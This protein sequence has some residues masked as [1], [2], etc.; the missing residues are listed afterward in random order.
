MRL[1]AEL[2]AR[3]HTRA[4]LSPHARM[5]SCSLAHACLVLVGC[6]S[7]ALV[8]CRLTTAPSPRTTVP[9]THA[10]LPPT[11]AQLLRRVLT[12]SLYDEL[13]GLRTARG[14][15]LDACIRGGVDWSASHDTGSVVRSAKRRAAI[16]PPVVSTPSIRHAR[17]R[18][19]GPA[20]RHPSRSTPCCQPSPLLPLRTNLSSLLSPRTRLGACHERRACSRATRTRTWSSRR[21]SNPS[22]RCSHT[23]TRSPRPAAP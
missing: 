1:C 17:V 11:Q 22:S 9:C 8:A 2:Y 21:C 10:L 13:R 18:S 23:Q 3:T 6:R 19:R 12:R 15:S 5:R 14:T 16:N 20:V 4:T 7:T